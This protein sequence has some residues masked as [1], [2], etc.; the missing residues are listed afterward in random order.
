[1][2]P[3]QNDFHIEG[4]ADNGNDFFYFLHLI[5]GAGNGHD[6]RGELRD[7]FFDVRFIDF[8]NDEQ[9]RPVSGTL[10]IADMEAIPR[11]NSTS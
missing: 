2:H 3:A 4:C 9:A 8:L 11:W 10:D 1:V 5:G 6:L 7:C